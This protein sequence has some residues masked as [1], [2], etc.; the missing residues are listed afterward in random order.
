MVI[1]RQ[2]PVAAS[3]TIARLQS[4]VAALEAALERRSRE[5]QAIQ[6]QVCRRD[7]V[8]IARVVSG[9]V[10]PP[11]AYCEP[12]LWHETTRAT[13]ADVEEALTGLWGSLQAER[14]GDG[15][16]VG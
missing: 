2:F 9:L 14:A 16:D 15:P 13:A 5:L 8:L 11:P 1:E 10:T 6:R 7:L 4:R 12:E 3:A